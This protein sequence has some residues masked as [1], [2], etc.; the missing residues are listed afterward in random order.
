MRQSWCFV[1]FTAASARC[2]IWGKCRPSFLELSNVDTTGIPPRWSK[3]NNK[4]SLLLNLHSPQ[5]Q[6]RSYSNLLHFGQDCAIAADL[7]VSDVAGLTASAATITNKC[8]PV[9]RPVTFL[10]GCHLPARYLCS[11]FPAGL[12]SK[13]N[14]SRCHVLPWAE[15]S[16]Q[17]DSS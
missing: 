8:G 1:G 6:W 11:C 7:L 12:P 13:Q 16:T 14:L 4:Q 9:L 10:Q 3:K 17:L 2:F 5:Q 15:A